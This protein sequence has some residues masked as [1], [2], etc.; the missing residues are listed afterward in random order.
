MAKTRIGDLAVVYLVD[1]NR[2]VIQV[3][4]IAPRGGVYK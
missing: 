1:K 2:V 4:R 3:I